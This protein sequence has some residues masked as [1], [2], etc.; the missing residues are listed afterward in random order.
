ME[1]NIMARRRIKMNKIRTIIRLNETGEMSQ[2]KIAKALGISRPVVKQYLIEFGKSE[3]SY[4]QIENIGDS[5]LLEIFDKQKLQKNSKYDE[6]SKSFPVYAKELKRTGVTLHRLW[7]E[8]KKEHA[9]GYSYSQ[10]CYHYQIWS[11]ASQITMH[12]EHKAGDAMY[13]DYAGDKLKIV[14]PKTGK[15]T[16]VETFAAIL[17]ASQ[18]TYVEV[19]YSQKKEDWIRSNERAL[20]YFGGVPKE[21]VPDNLKSAI[22]KP[23]QYDPDVNPEFNDFAKHYGIAILPARVAKPKDK[24]LVENAVKII[25]QRIYAALRD[26]IFY[27][28]E[29][30]NQ[31]IRELLEEHNNKKFQR[32]KCSRRVLFEEIEKSELRALPL[33]KYPFKNFKE[34]KVQY[35]YHIELREDKHYYS[36][37]YQLRGQKVRVFYDERTVS[38]YHDNL[39]IVEHQRDRRE[40]KYTTILTHMPKE[41]QDFANPWDEKRFLN[42]AE[43]IGDETK[44][45]VSKIFKITQYPG[46]GFKNCMGILN[47]TKQY[48][49]TRLNKACSRA[50]DF[51]FYSYK[52]IKNILENSLENET[53]YEFEF[54]KSL[55]AEHENIR[56]SEYYI[57]G[58]KNH[59]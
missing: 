52:R 4:K 50:L 6:L 48:D 42:W 43:S 49:P 8:Y 39:R 56:G 22:T 40:N 53:Q 11:N 24:S 35:N 54:S 37:P 47:L 44:T 58:E 51:G 41:H 9:K 36:V 59:G 26:R 15:E 57:S 1:A 19:S 17:G 23:D 28:L 13:V 32:M 20:W 31:A 38:I 7:T 12:I 29:E 16:Q 46:H 30:L 27:S 55:P 45:L 10:F 33:T 14:D 18:L 5:E 3:L 21:L 25:Y 2:R 34:L